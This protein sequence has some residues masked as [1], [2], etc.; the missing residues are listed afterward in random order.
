MKSLDPDV[1][2][3]IERRRVHPQRPAEASPGY[4]ED[5]SEPRE[6]M[7]PAFHRLLRGVDPE[8]AVGVEQ[9][10][11]VQDTHSTDVLRPNLIRPQD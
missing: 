2:A 11:A 3:Q 9:A 1:V 7:Q 8:A 10:S 6:E 4:V 5:L